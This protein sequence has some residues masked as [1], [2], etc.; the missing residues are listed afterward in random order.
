[1]G[2]L[3]KLIRRKD[4]KRLVMIGIDG[5]P[6]G[7]IKNLTRSGRMPHLSRLF[8]EGTLKKMRSS[9]PTVSSVAWTTFMTGTNPGKHGIFG[10]MDRQPDSY[11]IYFT[12]RTHIQEPPVWDLIA[13][14][15]KR[16]IVIN[17]PQTYP[18]RAMNGILVAGFV[19]IDLS[20][21][22][23]PESLCT[24]LETMDYRIDVD[25]HD[26]ANRTDEFFQDLFYTLEKRRETILHF[27]AREQWDLFMGV[28]TGTD[29]LHHYFWEHY[30][31][32]EKPFHKKFIEYYERLDQIIGEICQNVP[33]GT[34]LILM[35]DH[36]FGSLVHEVYPNTW[37]KEK[38][39]L[40]LRKDPP[41]SFDDIHPDTVAYIMDPGRIYINLKGKMPQGSVEPGTPYE[42]LRR[43]IAEGLKNLKAEGSGEPLVERVFLKEDVF[44]GPYLDKAP[45]LIAHTSFRH[46]IKGSLS[47]SHLVG[48]ASFTGMHTY[49][50]ASFYVRGEAANKDVV[51]LV[52]VVPTILTLMG[53]PV[54]DHLDG[55]SLV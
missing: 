47:K 24:Q 38:G 4:P 14:H 30:E 5:V 3:D 26:A 46:D 16:S 2:I 9:I 53:L 52:D 45:D 21:A 31:D 20:R 25:Y 1:M 55:A 39:Y 33:E 6:Y 35:S 43:E 18:A 37:L 17:L 28:F 22:V 12:N 44:S 10:F 50:D 40:K 54:P 48:R 19:A 41:E 27:L 13:E 8:K 51:D 29:R 34:P 7:L 36:G 15:G 42:D 23:Y 11:K 49:P 32:P